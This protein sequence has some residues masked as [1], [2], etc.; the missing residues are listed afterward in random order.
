MNQKGWVGKTTDTF[1][2]A[3]ACAKAGL[4]T[5]MVG[6]D[7]RDNLTTAAKKPRTKAPA[8]LSAAMLRPFTGPRRLIM[9][10]VDNLSLLPSGLDMFTLDRDLYSARA[11]REQPGR[12]LEQ[13]GEDLEEDDPGMILDQRH[14]LLVDAVRATGDPWDERWRDWVPV[15]VNDSSW[16]VSGL[17]VGFGG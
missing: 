14:L 5:L 10:V 6:L 1:D 15:T 7:P 16:F 17:G 9:P 11:P 8:T 12:V 4:R 13:T 2:L 3:G